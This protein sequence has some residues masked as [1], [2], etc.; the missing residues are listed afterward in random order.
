[1]EDR[2]YQ[3]SVPQGAQVP[4]G[5]RRQPAPDTGP[6]QALHSVNGL[7]KGI[8]GIHTPCKWMCGRHKITPRCQPPGALLRGVKDLPPILKLDL[9]SIRDAFRCPGGNTFAGNHT[10]MKTILAFVVA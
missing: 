3:L 6:G 10:R 5:P 1:A 2:M 8:G 9:N 4:P 7:V